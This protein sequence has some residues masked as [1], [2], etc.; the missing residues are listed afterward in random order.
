MHIFMEIPDGKQWFEIK[1]LVSEI[2]RGGNKLAW[3]TPD[4]RFK[5]QYGEGEYLEKS[6]G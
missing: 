4:L 2:Q 5:P 3:H 1:V 6:E